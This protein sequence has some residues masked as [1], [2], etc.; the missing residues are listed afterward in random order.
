MVFFFL[1][2]NCWKSPAGYSAVTILLPITQKIRHHD[3][4]ESYLTQ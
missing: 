3:Q 4:I 2:G 1:D